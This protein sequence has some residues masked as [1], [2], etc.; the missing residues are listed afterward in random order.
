MKLRSL[1]NGLY[2]AIRK[3]D[4]KLIMIGTCLGVAVTGFLSARA[5][6]K[7][8]RTVD[9]LKE[10]NDGEVKLGTVAK[11]TWKDVAFAVASGAATVGGII[12][13]EKLGANKLAASMAVGSF[14]AS[15]YEEIRMRD[16]LSSVVYDDKGKIINHG[17]SAYGNARKNDLKD[18]EEKIEKN[19]PVGFDY[20]TPFTL[21]EPKTQQY[22]ENVTAAKL[23]IAELSAN[24]RLQ[25][26]FEVSLNYI[27]C[28]LGGKQDKSCDLYWSFDDEYCCDA[29]SYTGAPWIEFRYYPDVIGGKSVVYLDFDVYPAAEVMDKEAWKETLAS[30]K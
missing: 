14:F 4:T 22:I 18:L 11:E 3:N 7:V 19:D 12:G 10:E 8:G 21:Y 6:A 9:K 30:K 16:I 24:R 28:L 23:I 1:A 15:K 29:W 25:S 26:N 27:I 13:L 2:S 20:N 5:G 17:A